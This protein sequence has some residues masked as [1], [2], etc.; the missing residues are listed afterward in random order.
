MK[1]ALFVIGITFAVAF[2]IVLGIRISPDALAIIVG[3]V[4][5]AAAS[6]PASLLVAFALTRQRQGIDR[7]PP[8]QPPGIVVAPQNLPAQPYGPPM[9]AL[10]PPA[11]KRTFTIIGE[12]SS[13]E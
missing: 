10:P 9:P 3:V 8:Q 12:D 13:Q 11:S 7:L 6:I 4:L 5:G 1:R 2:A